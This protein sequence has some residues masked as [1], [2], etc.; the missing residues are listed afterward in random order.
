MRSFG[1]PGN[2]KTPDGD[3]YV[4]INVILPGELTDEQVELIEK[5]REAGV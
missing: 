1:V 5:L 4:H 2:G 3:Q